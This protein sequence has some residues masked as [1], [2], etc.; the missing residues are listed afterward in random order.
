MFDGRELVCDAIHALYNPCAVLKLVQVFRD[1]DVPTVPFQIV[2]LQSNFW[3]LLR[4]VRRS[5]AKISASWHT[6]VA[7][8]SD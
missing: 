4:D 7:S 5:C 6:D 8:P 1:Q 3:K 2:V